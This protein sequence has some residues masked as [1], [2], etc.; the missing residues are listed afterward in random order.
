[1][2]VRRTQ[3]NSSSTTYRIRLEYLYARRSAINT[4]IESLEDYAK[5]RARRLEGLK[6][7][8]A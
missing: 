6:L 7:K 5:C 8:T 1:M 2:L 4:L 3:S